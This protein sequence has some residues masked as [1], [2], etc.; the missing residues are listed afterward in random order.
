MNL[1]IMIFAGLI[2]STALA[3]VG[4]HG[5]N[6]VICDGQ[7]PVTLDYYNATLPTLDGPVKT[8][9][10][11]GMSTAEAIATLRSRFDGSFF[12]DTFSDAVN[13]FG[14]YQSWPLADLAQVDD[15]NEPYILPPHCKRVTGMIRQ[16]Q[17][18][19]VDPVVFKQL[20]PSQRALLY[21]HEMLYY[22]SGMDSSEKIREMFRIL[23]RDDLTY[24]DVGNAVHLI[25]QSYYAM[26]FYNHVSGDLGLR[27]SHYTTM[28]YINYFR[29]VKDIWLPHNGVPSRIVSEGPVQRSG[30]NSYRFSFPAFDT[31]PE[32]SCSLS[33][34]DVKHVLFKCSDMPE[35]Y[36]QLDVL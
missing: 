36:L 20:S 21:V 19:Y 23:M 30:I 7:P 25:D 6:V 33:F 4:A 32:Q 34:V 8:T 9:D 28:A 11:A 27:D 26:D 5:G 31:H 22:I 10:L 2:V 29:E 3:G 16:D 17:T 18:I 14:P 12:Q 1:T 35:M 15:S 13:K 24:V